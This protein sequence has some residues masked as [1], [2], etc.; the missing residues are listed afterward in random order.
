MK[1]I[2]AALFVAGL[3]LLPA[4]SARRAQA[5]EGGFGFYLFGTKTSL[6]GFVPPPG[7]YFA[8]YNYYYSGSADIDFNIGGVNVN[9]GSTRTPTSSCSPGF[10]WHPT[11]SLAA[12]RPSALR[13]RSAGRVSR[14]ERRWISLASMTWSSIPTTVRTSV[15]LCWAPHWVGTR[16]TG[17]GASVRFINVP[18]GYWEKGDVTNIGFNRWA[19][20]L[21]GAVTYLDMKTGVELSA[22]LAYFQWREP[23]HRLPDR[24]GVPS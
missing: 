20:D 8:D 22:P 2:A 9:G 17:T 23:R 11:R 3:G 4:A 14:P 5:A 1:R 16:A 19:A 12:M 7:T 10:R 21:T 24:H 13:S 18:I 15:I 6:A